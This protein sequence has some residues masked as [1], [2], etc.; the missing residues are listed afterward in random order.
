MGPV[1]RRRGMR[2]GPAVLAVAALFGL[3]LVGCNL[4]KPTDPEPPSSR[5][6]LRTDYSFPDSTLR[7]IAL[8]I[9]DKGENGRLAYLNALADTTRDGRG[10]H[11]IFLPEVV[12]RFQAANATIPDD[13][14][15]DRESRF[16]FNFVAKQPGA[17]GMSWELDVRDPDLI[18]ETAGSATLYRRY[19]VQAALVGGSSVTLALGFARLDFILAT[20]NRW[21]IIRWED[22]L[23]PAP[24]GDYPDDLTFGSRRLELQ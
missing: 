22:R 13:W 12:R 21:V 7:T 5:V 20:G 23:P 2:H 10:F 8:A 18:D 15:R 19:E 4:F 16:Y 6:V 17:Y 9:A 24:P 14:N 1:I 3:P 11:A